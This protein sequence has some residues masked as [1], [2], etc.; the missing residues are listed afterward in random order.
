MAVTPTG[1]T[2]EAFGILDLLVGISPFVFVVGLLV[3]LA[4][5]GCAYPLARR[6]DTGFTRADRFEREQHLT[7]M[8]LGG[9]GFLAS[10][11][12]AVGLADVWPV[13][14]FWWTLVRHLLVVGALAVP[15]HVLQYRDAERADRRASRYLYAVFV[16]SWSVLATVVT[17]LLVG[18]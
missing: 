15:V 10:A 8:A 18:A 11:W 9:V 7:P 14:A 12:I 5:S 6:L 3:G 16:V 4:A 2:G 1:D 17:F 13:D